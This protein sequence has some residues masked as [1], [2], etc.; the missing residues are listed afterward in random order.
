M[1]LG[2]L[3][4]IGSE[5]QRL[6]LSGRRIRVEGTVQGVGFRPW[7]YR[8]AHEE[9]ILGTVRNDSAGVTVEAYGSADA[10]EAFLGRLEAAPPPA[11]EIRALRW[12]EL[13]G[14][15]ITDFTIVASDETAERRV[16]IPADL[17]TCD[18]CR[19]EITDPA[20]RRYGYPFTNC[21]NC[22]PRFTITLDVPY[23][24][25]ATTM[26]GFTLCPDCRREYEDP[27]DRRFHA[28][29]NACPVCGPQ[30]ALWDSDGRADASGSEALRAAAAAVRAGEVVAVK[31]LGGFHLVV[32][33]RDAAAVARLRRRKHRYEKPLAVM[34]PDLE[35]AGGLCE[36]TDEA[37]DLLASPM[38]PIVLLRRRPRTEIA[39]EVAPGNPYLG[40][41][42]PYT[43]LH[44]LLMA[45]LGFPVVATSGNLS[46]E[47]ICTDEREALDRLG[48]IA[49]RFLVHDRP[50]ARHADDSVAFVLAG[51][52]RPLRRARGWAPTPVALG[53]QAPPL[54]AVGAHLKNTVAVTS[55]DNVF[56]SQHVGDMETPQACRAFAAVIAD[57]LQMCRV[58]PVAIAHD[59]HPDYVSTRW[60]REAAGAAAAA[61]DSRPAAGP[62]TGMPGVRL[63]AVQ[64]HHAHLASC[65]ADADVEGPALGVTWDGTGY[66]TDGTIWGGELLLGDAAGFT[67][68][69]RLRPFLLPGGEA[70]VREPRRTALSLLWQIA[71]EAALSE[72]GLA[73]V[74]DLSTTDRGVLSRMLTTGLNSP[75]TTSVGRLFDGLAA[76]TGLAQRVS[77]E[78]QAAMAF[79]HVAQRSVDDAY[80]FDLASAEPT[81]PEDD[82]GLLEIDWRPL[83][84]AALEDVRRGTTTGIIS[85]RFHN[86]LAGAVVELAQR[87]GERRVALSGGCFQNRLL[88]QAVLRGLEAADFEV[89]LHRRVPANDGGI[90]LGQ[91]AVAAARLE[92]PTSEEE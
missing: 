81:A 41:M 5:S 37:A 84:S 64:H 1:G 13:P 70:A 3:R 58:E 32:D 19:R 78:G 63:I 15:E 71:G 66:G 4:P 82:P 43:P 74:K 83:V 75:T 9:G 45:E 31:G 30:L 20:D 54:L 50:I 60:A 72:D 22:G 62:V 47:P 11:A 26:A 55:G 85:A 44:A 56:I 59:L 21:T 91:I 8:L 6:N 90:S 48:G 68:V 24:R 73:P 23:D 25:P 36:L 33:A 79:E 39:D 67:R 16:S 51:A 89:L 34:V 49:D 80:P 10:L 69:G 57:L 52:P 86:A 18:D 88:T 92:H 61:N 46:D 76:L 27:L 77:F 12:Q 17:A 29:P 38:A 87:V 35:T 14:R 40:I 42:L 28:Q 53:R 65:L 2:S 7:V